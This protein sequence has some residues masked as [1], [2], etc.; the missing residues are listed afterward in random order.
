[1][2]LHYEP[3]TRQAVICAARGPGTDWVRNLRVAPATRVRIGRDSYTQ[4]TDFS[5]PTTASPSLKSS[6]ARTHGG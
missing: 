5:P 2:V 4:S 3:T 1:M 6:A